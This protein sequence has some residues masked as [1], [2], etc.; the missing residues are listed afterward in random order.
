MGS[1][2]SVADKYATPED[3]PPV[4][5]AEYER[6]KDTMSEAEIRAHL[7]TLSDSA[8]GEGAASLSDPAST[9]HVDVTP[10]GVTDEESAFM[11]DALEGAGSQSVEFFTAAFK[12]GD[13]SV[14]VAMQRAGGAGTSKVALFMHGFGPDRCFGYWLRFFPAMAAAG[15]S[16]IAL[17]HPGSGKSTGKADKTCDAHMVERLLPALGV[18]ADSGCVCMVGDGMGAATLVR[19]LCRS[20]GFFSHNHLLINCQISEV[21]AEPVPQC[22][23]H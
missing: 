14:N 15:I 19:A 8:A 4:L 13:L 1:G 7:H 20:P 6:V 17:D 18:P 3:L 12:K 22:L 11:E 5:R 16:C 2:V 23:P 21:P 9:S 10:R